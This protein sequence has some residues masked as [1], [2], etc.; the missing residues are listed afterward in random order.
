MSPGRCT[1]GRC[2]AGM[3]NGGHCRPFGTEVIRVNPT[4]MVGEEVRSRTPRALGG[5]GW[6]GAMKLARNKSVVIVAAVVVLAA[7]V[8]GALLA[9]RGGGQA[10]RTAATP[11]HSQQLRSPFTGEP[12]PSLNRV[13]AV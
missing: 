9:L 3:T 7:L 13:L 12:V 10:R 5:R 2:T 4:R 6:D 11:P 8:A 1:N